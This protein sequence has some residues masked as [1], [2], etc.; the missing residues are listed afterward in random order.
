ASI[1]DEGDGRRRIEFFDRDG[2]RRRIRL[3][4]I[5]KH[6]AQ[7]FKLRITKIVGASLRN[8]TPDDETN[9]WLASLSDKLHARI[10]NTGLVKY[11][12]RTAATLGA[13]LTDCFESMT[14]K[15]GTATAYGHT[16][17][18]LLDYFGENKSLRDIEPADA[19]KWR[20]WL[21]TANLWEKCD[22]LSD[23]TINRRV[24]VARMIFRRAVRWKLIRENPFADVKAG[25]QINKTRQF[26]VT[27][28]M[29]Q[30]VLDTCPDSQWKLLFALSRY[31]GLRC[32]SEH[33]A[34]KWTDVDFDRKRIRV[35]SPKTEHHEGM[36][37]RMIPLFPE[38]EPLLTTALAEAPEGTE[39]VITRYRDRN[40]NLRTQLERII[41]K[42][43][44][45]PWPKLFH[46]LRSSR[47][48]ELAERYPIHVV[49][50]WIGNSRAVAQEHYLQVTDAHFEAAAKHVEKAAQ[51]PA[52]QDAA[53]TRNDQSVARSTNENRSEFPSDA[54]SSECLHDSPVGAVGFEPTKA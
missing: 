27:R 41:R 51:N 34:L 36:D 12:N 2:K 10:A 1:V 28:E 4:E 29:T 19:D 53:S 23:S 32:P 38:L 21:R 3:G 47:Q 37:S 35:P 30:Q 40:C 8:D 39:Y 48:T 22:E 31:G 33:L 52:Q 18:C 45:T 17:R 11:R 25:N 46:N 42:A 15:P 43:K 16:R 26:F 44:L 5:N 20:Q 9:R 7:T 49:C 14:V 6:D 13:F 24:G 54:K 50:Q